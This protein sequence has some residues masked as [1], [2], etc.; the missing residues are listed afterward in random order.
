MIRAL[1]RLLSWLLDLF[2]PICPDCEAHETGVCDGC[3]PL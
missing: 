1:D 3:L 2:F